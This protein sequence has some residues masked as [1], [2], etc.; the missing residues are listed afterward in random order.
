M[1]PP[2]SAFS[3]RIAA[4]AA[5]IAALSVVVLACSAP[6]DS[7]TVSP[8]ALDKTG[9][10]AV[11]PVLNRRCGSIDCHGSRFRN[12]RLYGFGGVRLAATDNP[13][14]PPTTQAE[15]AKDYEAV[16]GLEPEVMRSFI[17][18][19]RKDPTTLTLLRK[20]RNA[21]D[22]KGG[23]RLVPGDA[24]DTCL[25]SWLTATVDSSA[26]ASAAAERNPLDR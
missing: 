17:D 26:C 6:D 11:A 16:M 19:G 23:K 18:S 15:A 10:E 22:H 21:E 24:A 9:F 2:R 12:L 14:S 7:A 3:P 13:E 20:A 8:G 1:S 5:W 4:A 25:V